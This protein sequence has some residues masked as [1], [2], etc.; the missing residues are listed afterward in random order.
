MTYPK[1]KLKLNTEI[2]SAKMFHLE[3][4]KKTKNV[5]HKKLTKELIE[6]IE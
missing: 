1:T 3:Q 6:R 2:G 4:M 5:A